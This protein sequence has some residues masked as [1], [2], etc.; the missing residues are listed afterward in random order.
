M[1]ALF[2]LLPV[3]AVA[4]DYT[5]GPDSQRQPGVPEGKVSQHTWTSKLFPGT[6]RDYW[7]YVPAQYKPGQPA[8]AMIFQDGAGHISP[9]GAWRTPLVFDNLIHNGQ[10]PVTIGVFINPGV[11]PALRPEHQARYNRSFEYDN[12]SD[13]YARFLVEEILPEVAKHYNLSADPNH[14]AVAGSSSGGIAAFMAAWHRPDAFRRVLSFIG[15]YVNLRGGQSVAS[16]IRKTEPKPLR[17]YLQDG[18]NDQNIYAGH[19]F[20]GNEDVAAALAFSG[21]DTTF[22]VG[23]EGH[24]SRHGAAILPD[25]LRW[26]W[27]DYPAP[28]PR[29]TGRG[30]RH[31]VTSILADADW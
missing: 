2:L 26:L 9:S 6:V 29:P 8:C 24:N 18:R 27:R 7:I 25:A 12:L 11:L 23:S 22:V 17:V 15:S 1:R 10:M 19:W 14:R 5:L 28:I 20:I 21:Y 31:F 13:R 3:L 30:E 4:Q 16:L